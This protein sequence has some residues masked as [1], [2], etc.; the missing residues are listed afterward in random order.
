MSRHF[1]G[2]LL[3]KRQLSSTL[4]SNVI[5][6]LSTRLLQINALNVWT[7]C[8]EQSLILHCL[9]C[10]MNVLV[11]SSHWMRLSRIWRILQIKEGVIHPEWRPRWITPSEICRIFDNDPTKA[12]FNNYFIIHSKYLPVLKEVL[13]FH[14]VLFCSPKITKPQSPGSWSMVQ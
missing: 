6:K 4:F 13:P 12:E 14:S 9:P 8:Y 11:L 5:L 7:L 3:L 2:F 1:K 10:V